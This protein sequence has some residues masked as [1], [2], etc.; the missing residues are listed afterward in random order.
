MNVRNDKM[1]LINIIGLF[2]QGNF[3]R[4]LTEGQWVFCQNS[5]EI[6]SMEHTN[7]FSGDLK[8]ENFMFVMRLMFDWLYQEAF[9]F[10]Q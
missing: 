2:H 6:A 8:D 10:F 4:I 1:I 7:Y 5:L 3:L 9:I